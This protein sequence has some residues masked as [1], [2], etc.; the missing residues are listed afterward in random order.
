MTSL[1]NKTRISQNIPLRL[2]RE[3]QPFLV[4]IYYAMLTSFL[5]HE[6]IKNSGSYLFA[7]HIYVGKPKGR[8]FVGALLDALLLKLPSSASFR[9]RY[10]HTRDGVIK[11]LLYSKSQEPKRVLSVPCGIPR[12]LV[13]AATCLRSTAPEIYDRTMF[14]CVDLDPQTIEEAR[15]FVE[16]HGHRNFVFASADALK[17]ASYPLRF[18]CIVSTGFNE[19]IDDNELLIFFTNAINALGEDGIFITSLT[20]KHYLSDYLMKNVAELFV[21]YRSEE[22]LCSIVKTAG[23]KNVTISCDPIGYQLFI[24][25]T[26]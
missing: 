14:Y 10:E 22:R 1:K 11:K 16:A 26:K 7:D 20:K 21:H 13:E 24:D 5:A 9:K 17:S 6:G 2:L 25:A 12:E 3:G 15:R 19:F 8:F 4:P 18:D 23:A